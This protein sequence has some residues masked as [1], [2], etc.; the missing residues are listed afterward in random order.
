MR[1]VSRAGG[2]VGV[3]ECM[4]MGDGWDGGWGMDGWDGGLMMMDE[5]WMGWGIDDDG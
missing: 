4:G 3:D 5:G 2:L 1:M